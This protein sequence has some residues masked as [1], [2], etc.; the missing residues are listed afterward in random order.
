MKTVLNSCLFSCWLVAVAA[1]TAC[2]SDRETRVDIGNRE[3]ILHIANGSEPAGI[4]PHTTT[5]S[6]EK[7]IQY[8]LFEGLVALDPQTL[9][10]IP[11]VAETWDI[12]EDGKTYRFHIRD[13]ARWSNGDPL[14]AEDFVWS[15][16]R[17]LLPALGN[18]YAYSLYVIENAEA[19]HKGQITDFSA[20]GVKAI[21]DRTLEVVLNHPT[22][23]FLELLDHHSMFAVHRGTIEKAGAPD[24]RASAW[25]KPHNFVGNGPF[26]IKEWTPNKVF[27]VEKN[28]HYWDAD[29]V[30]L[31]EVHFYP[32]EKTSAEERMFRAG[33]LHITYKLPSS[34]VESYRQE[35]SGVLRSFPFFGTYFYL[36]NVNKPPLDDLRVRKALT[37]SVDRA[38]ITQYVTKGGETP[39]YN[40][41]PPDTNGYTADAK[42]VFDVDLARHLLAEAG[43]PNG[44]GFPS[45]TLLYNTEETHQQ[46]AVAIQ[47]MWKQALNIHVTLEN[48]DWK[49]YLANKRIKNYQ[50]ARLGW[51]GDYYDPNTFLDLFVT[52][53]GNN[54]TGWSN[55]RY[56]EL[57]R[58]ASQ[59]T[60]QEERYAYFQ[61]AEALLV[62][63][64]PILPIYTYA[65][66]RL[67][68]PSVKGW[69]DNVTDRW[70][71]KHVYLESQASQ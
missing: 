48:Q 4:D 52:N 7:N 1:L 57:I 13:K 20:V 34:K 17:A 46:V 3:Q 69:Y 27:A 59:A 28:P 68:Q 33:Q 16:K 32:I 54:D 31:K 60:S 14:T 25:T 45:L 39:A 10:V 15:W 36:F 26:V 41:T 53:G 22:S 5:G 35:N 55:A 47:Q 62:A 58:L 63:E 65:W 24:D 50:M 51:M 2:S 11:G 64:V 9:E 37:Y 67:V 19:F 29:S 43:Y 44:Q 40:L 49:V 66:N 6:P 42:V 56:D 38:Q 18:E 8:A 71:F 30:K 61:E 21:D 70:S 12:S 23:Y